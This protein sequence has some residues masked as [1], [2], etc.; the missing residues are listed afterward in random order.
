MIDFT[1]VLSDEEGRGRKECNKPANETTWHTDFFAVIYTR[2]SKIKRR[3]SIYYNI[4]S[5]V[6]WLDGEWIVCLRGHTSRTD[7]GFDVIG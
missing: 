3:G 1:R 7:D 2:I 5:L 4:M 6:D